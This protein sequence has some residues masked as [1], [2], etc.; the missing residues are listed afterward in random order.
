MFSVI[1]GQSQIETKNAF[2]DPFLI[3]VHFIYLMSNQKEI[4]ISVLLGFLRDYSTAMTVVIVFVKLNKNNFESQT[5]LENVA[6]Y[7]F[8]LEVHNAH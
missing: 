7:T 8:F 1:H 3:Y 4:L 6:Y 2:L 5:N